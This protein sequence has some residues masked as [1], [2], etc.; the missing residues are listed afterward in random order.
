MPQGTKPRALVGGKRPSSW[1]GGTTL[2]GLG[3]P[4]DL[5]VPGGGV[6]PQWGDRR[7]WR[8]DEGKGPPVMAAQSQVVPWGS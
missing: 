7:R 6:G 5:G 3:L 1:G 8:D 2:P 4:S